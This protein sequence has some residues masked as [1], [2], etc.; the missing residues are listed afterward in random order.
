MIFIII[1]LDK[2]KYRKIIE[3]NIISK[4]ILLKS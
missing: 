3:D 4:K 2:S 1:V